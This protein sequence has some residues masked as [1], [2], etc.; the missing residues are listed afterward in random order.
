[1]APIIPFPFDLDFIPPI[2]HRAEMERAKAEDKQDRLYVYKLHFT[3][4]A[5]V[6]GKMIGEN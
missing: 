6:C 2:I 3:T 1:M 5:S 4:T